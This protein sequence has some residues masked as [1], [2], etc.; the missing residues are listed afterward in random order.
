MRKSIIV[1]ITAGTVGLTTLGIGVAT[2]D[3]GE[4]SCGEHREG[5]WSEYRD[6]KH[7]KFGMQKMSLEHLDRKLELTD[8]QEDTLAPIL[9]QQF[10][11][12]RQ[13]MR[14]MK[15]LRKD[16]RGLDLAASDYQ[17]QLDA[18]VLQ[19]QQAA[20]NF[21]RS[22]ADLRQKIYAELTPEQQAKFTSSK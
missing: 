8:A 6:G 10:L 21:I 19:S 20:E 9:D 4:K 16:L 2:A 14:D 7:G 3:Q 15:S 12:M 18:L 17:Q 22:R 5:K 1:A 11:D 13:Q